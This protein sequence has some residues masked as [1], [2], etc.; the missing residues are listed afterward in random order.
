MLCTGFFLVMIKS[1]ITTITIEK[2]PKYNLGS[3]AQ[4]LRGVRG[5]V[6]RGTLYFSL[7]A[8]E[9]RLVLMGFKV[10]AHRPPETFEIFLPFLAGHVFVPVCKELVLVHKKDFPRIVG[11]LIM[12]GE[13]H[14]P[15]GTGLHTKS[16]IDTPEHFNLVAVDN[17][18]MVITFTGV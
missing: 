8:P 7:A 2:Y 9:Y 15:I 17:L 11:I 13:H 14:S 16:A 18:C 6:W 3:I 1:E 5:F 4:S 10:L 12:L